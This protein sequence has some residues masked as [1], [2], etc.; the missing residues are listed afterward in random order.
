MIQASIPEEMQVKMD[1]ETGNFSRTVRVLNPT[2][3]KDGESF[4]CL[5]G[6]DP[7]QGIIGSGH[8]PAEAIKDWEK[9]VQERLAAPSENDEVAQYAKDSLAASKKDVW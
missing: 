3:Y 5:L 8:T 9:Q 4:C 6:P 7:H 2:V 1:F